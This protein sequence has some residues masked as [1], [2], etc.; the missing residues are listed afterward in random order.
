MAH[1]TVEQMLTQHPDIS[2]VRSDIG[3]AIVTTLDSERRKRRVHV[4]PRPDELLLS[5][6]GQPETKGFTYMHVT[7]REGGGILVDVENPDPTLDPPHIVEQSRLGLALL[8]AFMD[9]PQDARHPMWNPWVD[10]FGR[11]GHILYDHRPTAELLSQP[12]REYVQHWPKPQ[13]P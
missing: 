5:I 12:V 4:L 7:P 10:D 6:P 2:V 13:S 1:E 3:E 9:T 8:S 11:K